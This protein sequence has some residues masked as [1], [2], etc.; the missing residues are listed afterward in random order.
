MD[1]RN[2]FSVSY[3]YPAFIATSTAFNPNLTPNPKAWDVHVYQTP[4]EFLPY[5]KI[6]VLITVLEWFAQN[7]F[8]YDGFQVYQALPLSCTTLILLP[9]QRNGTIYFEGEYAAISTNSSN[10]FGAPAQGRLTFPTMQ[11]Q[12]KFIYCALFS[13]LRNNRFRWR[14]SIYDWS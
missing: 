7:S 5:M 3:R 1:F 12:Y 9:P 10:I 11:S 2:R 4:R 14:S 8:I 13:N 6:S